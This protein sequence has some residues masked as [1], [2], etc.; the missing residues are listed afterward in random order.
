MSYEQSAVAQEGSTVDWEGIRKSYCAF[1]ANPSAY[2]GE[3]FVK[4]L[5][6]T[7]ILFLKEFEEKLK[8]YDLIVKPIDN[9]QFRRIALKGNI[10]AVEAVFR[11]LN[12]SDGS[13]T[14]MLFILLGDIMRLHP[15]L[16]LEILEKYINMDFF[17]LVGNAV[18]MNAMPLGSE[19][20]K[21]ELK[22]RIDALGTVKDE[23][24][25]GLRDACILELRKAIKRESK[26]SLSIPSTG[27]FWRNTMSRASSSATTSTSGVSS[28]PN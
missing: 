23:K 17:R 24:Y 12:M 26:G 13:G 19:E 10:Y 28:S 15:S 4:Q 27:G 14:E 1:V 9:S 25:L 6:S 3:V 8:T 2:N 20:E 22:A 5:P 7:P 16:Y 21:A 18:A 11:L